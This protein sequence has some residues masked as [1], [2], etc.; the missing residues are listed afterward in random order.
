MNDE[1]IYSLNVEDIQTVAKEIY[2]PELKIDEITSI[3][4]L[5]PERIDW[6]GVIESIILEKVKE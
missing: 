6:F 3:K 1:I 2:N 4:D 5:I